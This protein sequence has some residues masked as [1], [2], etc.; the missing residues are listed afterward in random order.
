MDEEEQTEN[1]FEQEED[2]LK[3]TVMGTIS[4]GVLWQENNTYCLA[5]EGGE[6]EIPYFMQG[7]GIARNCGLFILVPDMVDGGVVE[8]LK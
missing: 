2:E 8:Y 4:H 1:P 3:T 7:S 6:M 5:Y